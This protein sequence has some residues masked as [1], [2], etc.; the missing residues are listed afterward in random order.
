[1]LVSLLFLSKG[2]AQPKI[3]IKTNTID[4]GTVIEG[5]ICKH[6]FKF[7]NTGNVP[8]VIENVDVT[9]G[10][11]VPRW[12]MKPIKPGDTSS[13]YIEFNTFNKMGMQA[14]GVNLTTNCIPKEFGFIIL[15]NVIPDSNFKVIRDSLTYKPFQLIDQKSY[16]Q[17]TVDPEKLVKKKFR[18]NGFDLE[19][20]VK[21]ILISKYEALSESIWYTSTSDKLILNTYDQNIKKQ[22]GKALSKEFSRK[23]KVKKWIAKF[24]NS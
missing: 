5:T 15:A 10:C 18:G 3:E 16:Y 1:M 20:L 17:V 11:T 13:V 7:K 22:L 19:R 12:D 8:L 9:C 4:F 14:K 6:S 23:R 2:F 24:K 21:F